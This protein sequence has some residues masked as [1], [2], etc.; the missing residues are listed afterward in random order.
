MS[1]KKKP[2]KAISVTGINADDYE[3]MACSEVS[4]AVFIR[5]AIFDKILKEKKEKRKSK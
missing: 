3:Y 4:I 1:E 5:A 2:T